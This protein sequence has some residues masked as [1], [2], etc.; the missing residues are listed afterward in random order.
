MAHR[1]D[2]TP[3]RTGFRRS[4]ADHLFVRAV[5]Q[6]ETDRGDDEGLTGARLARECAGAGVEGYLGS[7]DGAEIFHDQLVK[8]LGE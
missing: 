5:P 1:H 6:Q 8:H 2:E 7:L 3:L 4:L